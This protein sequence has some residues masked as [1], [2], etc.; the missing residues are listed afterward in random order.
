MLQSNEVPNCPFCDE[1][2]DGIIVNGLHKRCSDELHKEMTRWEEE[3]EVFRCAELAG[4]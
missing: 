1:P 2:L 3:Y 4:Q